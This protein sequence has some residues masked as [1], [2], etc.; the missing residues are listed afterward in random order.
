MRDDLAHIVVR[1]SETRGARTISVE[2]QERD[3]RKLVA[4]LGLI[5]HGVSVDRS[6]SAFHIPPLQRKGLREA[7]APEVAAEYGTL[8]YYQQSRLCRHLFPDFADMIAWAKANKMRLRSVTEQGDPLTP[9]GQLSA[10][11]ISWKDEAESQ[12]KSDKMRDV[13]RDLHADGRWTGGRPP[14]GKRAVCRCHELETC[15]DLKDCTG[16][17]LR[18]HDA[19]QQILTLVAKNVTAGRSVNAVIANLNGAGILS[20]DGKAWSA[21]T[22]R[23][24]LRSTKAIDVIGPALWS[25]VQAAIGKPSAGNVGTRTATENPLLDLIWCGRCADAGRDRGKVYR[26]HRRSQDRYYGRCRNEL[27]RAEQRD[28]CDMPMIPF[29]LLEQ[30]AEADL[31]DEHG[32]DLIEVKVTDDAVSAAQLRV[33]EINGELV[34]IAADRA[35]TKITRAE[36]RERQAEL[37]DELD[38]LEN[39]ASE[40]AASA[41][42]RDT[43]ETVRERWG[44]LNPAGRRLWLIRIGTTWTVYRD[45]RDD[46]AGRW[47]VESSWQIADDPARR[48]RVVR[49]V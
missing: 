15:P 44:R 39:P 17:E 1:Q 18:I 7:L 43:G 42:W 36:A 5:V 26:W 27:K 22:M 8:I 29:E 32:D 40:V 33:E 20:T 34:R 49:A 24:I 3:C 41:G 9:E 47:R 37:E 25:E 46:G 12:A 2:Q 14:Y 31:L 30:A 10:V 11:V 21:H 4:D 6:T 35:A 13:Q 23:K 16:W 45:T 38:E 48:E 19:H 28:P